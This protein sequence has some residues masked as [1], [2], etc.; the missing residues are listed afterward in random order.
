MGKATPKTAPKKS[1]V[2]A[3]SMKRAKAPKVLTIQRDRS[4][5]KVMMSERE[6]KGS[7]T[8][9]KGRVSAGSRDAI[10]ETR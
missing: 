3:P 7:T 2:K 9:G 10:E 8:R 1:A 6:I 5:G 4:S